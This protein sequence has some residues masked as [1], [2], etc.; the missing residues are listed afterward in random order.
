MLLPM[1][2]HGNDVLKKKATQDKGETFTQMWN[3]LMQS[4][5]VFMEPKIKPVWYLHT[6]HSSFPGLILNEGWMK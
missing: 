1:S 2:K 3:V 4:F 5:I 6:N